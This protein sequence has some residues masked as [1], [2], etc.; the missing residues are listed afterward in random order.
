[1]I[2]RSKAFATAF[3]WSEASSFP[4]G[5]LTHSQM[6]P[7]LRPRIWTTSFGGIPLHQQPANHHASRRTT[8]SHPQTSPSPPTSP[9]GPAPSSKCSTASHFAATSAGPV[10]WKATSGWRRCHLQAVEP[11]TGVGAYA[12]MRALRLQIRQSSR[13]SPD[14]RASQA[15]LPAGASTHHRSDSD[16]TPKRPLKSTVVGKVIGALGLL[17]ADARRLPEQ[18]RIKGKREPLN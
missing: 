9:H 8:P 13:T 1:M 16:A 3:V 11:P 18:P 2:S 14:C 5:L 12:R 4:I 7:L 15:A 10:T 17:R 6:V